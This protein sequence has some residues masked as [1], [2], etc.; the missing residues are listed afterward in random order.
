MGTVKEWF[1]SDKDYQKGVEL[2]LKYGKNSNL[3]NR[4][5]MNDSKYNRDKLEYEL[6]KFLDVPV[7][8]KPVVSKVDLSI[9]PDGNFNT[10]STEAV[11]EV[12]IVENEQK[13]ALLFDDLP[14]TVRPF[15]LEANNAFKEL[16]LLKTELNEVPDEDEEKAF[17]IQKKMEALRTVNENAWR[18]IDYF[19]QTGKEIEVKEELL[20]DL[21]PAQ[22]VKRQQLQFQKVSKDK[23]SIEVLMQQLAGSESSLIKQKLKNKIEKAKHKLLIDEDILLKI[24]SLVDGK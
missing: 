15:L 6:S 20:T 3:K 11:A 10:V 8:H 9:S 12:T 16:C 18:K 1:D 22:L 21:S 23:K 17:G 7:A 13:T 2:Y 24:N 14:P 5:Q 4:F 19:L